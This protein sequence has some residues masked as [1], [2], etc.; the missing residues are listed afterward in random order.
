MVSVGRHRRDRDRVVSLELQRDV[1]DLD[2]TCAVDGES[3]CRAE[4]LCGLGAFAGKQHLEGHTNRRA[5]PVPG[6]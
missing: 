6:L 2:G 3:D 1:R 4:V 5:E